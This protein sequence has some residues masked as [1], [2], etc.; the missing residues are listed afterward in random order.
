MSP[1]KFIGQLLN[2]REAM[3]KELQGKCSLKRSEELA[4]QR[5]ELDRTSLVT[6]FDFKLRV[7]SVSRSGS[8]II[9]LGRESF[10]FKDGYKK[11]FIHVGS[12]FIKE[13]KIAESIRPGDK[14]RVIGKPVEFM[15]NA[16]HEQEILTFSVN[17]DTTIEPERR[18]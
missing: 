16:Y 6:H 8:F 1:T 4:E 2:K 14:I 15:Y 12:E 11:C 3:N 9:I 13:Q 18:F 17:S 7:E 10:T 5:R